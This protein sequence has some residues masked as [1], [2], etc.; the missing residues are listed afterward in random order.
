MSRPRAA[1]TAGAVVIPRKGNDMRKPTCTVAGCDKPSRNK[2][3]AAL[4]PMHYHR[5]YRHGDVETVATGLKTVAGRRYRYVRA[6][7]HPLA[8][9]DGRTYEHRVVLY[10]HLGPGPHPCHWCGKDVDWV[11][12][13]D[14]RC[15][16]PDHL[17]GDGADNE[18]TNLVPSCGTCNSARAA[19]SRSDLLR[20]RGWWSGNDTVARL[21]GGRRDRVEPS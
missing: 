5:Q 17:N 7:G 19:Q 14:P 6:D 12:K 11:A 9:K 10:D 1:L 18:I 15:L 20:S 8:D 4:C 3:S 13:G 2:D 16:M 21:S